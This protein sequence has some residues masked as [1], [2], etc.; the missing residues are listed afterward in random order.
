M[1]KVIRDFLYAQA[2]QP[3]VEVYSDWLTVGHVDE[4]LTFVPAS[5]RKV[6]CPGWEACHSFLAPCQMAFVFCKG[7]QGVEVENLGAGK[8]HELPKS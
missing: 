5:D 7:W 3:P 2:V 4:F 1:A 8:E 6:P